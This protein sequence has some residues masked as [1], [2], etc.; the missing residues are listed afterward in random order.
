MFKALCISGNPSAAAQDNEV[1]YT[2]VFYP[3]LWK[4]EVDSILHYKPIH[5]Q[6]QDSDNLIYL[7][8]QLQKAKGKIANSHCYSISLVYVALEM[9]ETMRMEINGRHQ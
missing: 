7:G 9:S 6:T 5:H 4:K 2:D 8:T 1:I 3:L